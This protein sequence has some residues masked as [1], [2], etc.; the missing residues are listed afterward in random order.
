MDRWRRLAGPPLALGLAPRD[1]Q[2][3]RIAA[4][5]TLQAWWRHAYRACAAPDAPWIAYL[6]VKLVAKQARVWLWLAA[7]ERAGSR[8]DVLERARAALPEE[9]E[10]FAFALDLHGRLRSAPDPPLDVALAAAA[11]LTDRVPQARV[12]RGVRG[13]G[14]RGEP[15]RPVGAP[16]GGGR[17]PPRAG[18]SGRRGQKLLPSRTGSRSRTPHGRTSGS[19]APTALRSAAHL[20]AAA[21][22]EESKKRSRSATSCPSRSAPRRGGRGCGP[23]SAPRPIRSPPRCSPGRFVARFPDVAGWSARDW[24]RR[25][26]N[27]QRPLLAQDDGSAERALAAARA[28][29]FRESVDAGAPRLAL[30]LADAATLLAERVPAERAAVEAGAA[31]YAAWRRDRHGDRPGDRRRTHP[32]GARAARTSPDDAPR[33][34]GQGARHL[35]ERWGTHMVPGTSPF[36]RSGRVRRM[37]GAETRVHLCGA[38]RVQ[39]LGEPR[40]DAFRRRQSLLLFAFLVLNRHRPVRRDE[41]VR[42]VWP[43]EGAPARADELLAPLLSRLR[44]AL[45]RS[46]SRAVRS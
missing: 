44:K 40:E 15:P 38:L 46:G 36:C 25:A 19:P 12:G 9:S 41:L 8:V 6:C 42:A 35:P 5:M 43:E 1:R 13:R 21:A 31:A 45:G 33:A 28:A 34:T 20:A 17:P 26:V 3:E 2:H 11:R 29:L 37:P 10:A 32:R 39:W 16:S 24:A 14:D 23:C 18:R 4:W 30:T 22:R 27:E 7:G